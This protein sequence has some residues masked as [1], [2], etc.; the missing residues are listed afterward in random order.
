[1]ASLYLAPM[2]ELTGYV[3]RNA[4]SRHFGYVDK[5][6]TP[7]ISPDNRIMKTRA[8][9]EIMP[10]N[11]EGL[12]VIPQLLTNDPALFNEAA[13]LIADMGYE[14]ININFGCPSNTVASKFKGSGILRAPDIMD[15]FLDGI[16][17]GNDSILNTNPGFRIS[18]KT[19][20]GYN[21]TSD[22]YKV[23]E[24]LNRYPVFEIIVHPRLKKDLY[25]GTIKTEMFEYVLENCKTRISYNGDVCSPQDHDRITEKYK[26]RIE[27]IMIGRAAVADPGI[28]RRI[29]TGRE[30]SESELYDFLSD[31]YDTYKSD[32]SPENALGKLKEVWSYTVGLIEDEKLRSRI[33][34]SIIKAKDESQYKDAIA[35]ARSCICL[36]RRD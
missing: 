16:F 24:I 13:K 25:S 36:N 28:F 34:K 10:A 23:V 26:G 1:M 32:F 18:V 22:L 12:C 5:F 3:F 35:V 19:R 4:I 21:D 27:G 33:H 15:R 11:N 20:V 14:E 2:E 29:R 6:Y 8:A 30:T 17:N 9:R 7:F 31:L